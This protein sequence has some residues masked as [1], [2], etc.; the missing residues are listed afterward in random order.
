MTLQLLA[1]TLCF[2]QAAYRTHG[3]H[4]AALLLLPSKAG[5]CKLLQ[6]VEDRRSDADLQGLKL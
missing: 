3:E 5:Y 4:A 2:K 1:N 6:L